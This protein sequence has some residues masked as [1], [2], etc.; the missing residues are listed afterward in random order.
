MEVRNA[1]CKHRTIGGGRS[2]ADKMEMKMQ[3][4]MNTSHGWIVGTK[5]IN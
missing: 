2:R 4:A 3:P 1:A 5:W